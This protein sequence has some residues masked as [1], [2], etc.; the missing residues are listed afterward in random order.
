MNA[1][2]FTSDGKENGTITL[3]HQFEEE[4]RPDLIK[5][6]FWAYHSLRWQPKGAYP[7]AGMQNTAEYYGR[8][9]AWRQTINTGR[10]RLPREKVPGGRSGRVLR[11]PHAVKGRR[12]HPPKVE[13][14]LVE[15]INK[16]EKNLA[17]RSAIAATAN[18]KVVV[19]RGHV[20]NSKVSLPIVADNSLEKAKKT[21]DVQKF[22]FSVGLE[23]DLH[24]ASA[25]R[26]MRSGVAGRR[27]GGYL[28]RKSVLIVYGE[29]AG[30][31]K[32]ARNIVGVDCASVESLNAE[33][34]APG[35]NAGRLCVWTQGALDKLSK[36]LYL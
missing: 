24:K 25:T 1:K 9:A 17:L 36:G 19:G 15:K 18:E 7:L 31:A 34:L 27:K 11:V 14:V 5:R 8:R 21:A 23:G 28:E 22:L 12:A 13:K 29:D 33:L 4:Y 16:R 32:A 30:I 6:A 26:V 35:G 10:S 20:L 3:P 2:L